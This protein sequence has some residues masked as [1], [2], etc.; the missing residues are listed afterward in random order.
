MTKETNIQK[1]E[2][3][4]ER[5]KTQLGLHEASDCKS[6]NLRIAVSARIKQLKLSLTQYEVARLKLRCS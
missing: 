3:E 5:I 1:I 4:I 6:P 2:I